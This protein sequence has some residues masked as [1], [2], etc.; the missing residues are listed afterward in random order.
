VSKETKKIWCEDE[1][2]VIAVAD[3]YMEVVGYYKKDDGV[4]FVI[5]FEKE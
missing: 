3:F 4:K 1:D 2:N 5:K